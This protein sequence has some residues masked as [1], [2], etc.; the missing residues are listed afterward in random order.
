MSKS[1]TIHQPMLFPP[2]YLIARFISVDHLVFL[3]T[4]WAKTGGWHT[5]FKLYGPVGPMIV[6]VWLKQKHS[7][8]INELQFDRPERF[9]QKLY[10]TLQQLYGRSPYYHPTME[11]LECLDA[12][13]GFSSYSMGFIHLVMD[14]LGVPLTIST[15][16]S[17]D[18]PRP[19]TAS[20]WLAEIGDKVWGDIYVCAQDATEKY[21][22]PAPFHEK[23]I[24]VS[25]QDYLMPPYAQRTGGSINDAS[26]SILDLLM[27]CSPD[28]AVAILRGE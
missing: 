19:D 18:V 8:R 16:A 11:L 10:K 23:G 7:T 21:L 26:A 17:L 15:D 5:R 4:D 14:Y 20:E 25:G 22:D 24:L 13:D 12:S 3:T 28:E 1:F 6:P 2:I 27:R 9:F